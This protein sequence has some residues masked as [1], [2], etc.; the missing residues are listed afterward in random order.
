MMTIEKTL[1]LM[2]YFPFDIQRSHSNS[3]QN[4]PRPKAEPNTSSTNDAIPQKTKG[5]LSK[6][7]SQYKKPYIGTKRHGGGG[8]SHGT[9]R[10]PANMTLPSANIVTR[11]NY[12]AYSRSCVTRANDFKPRHYYRQKSRCCFIEQFDQKL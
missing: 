12:S 7:L 4:S 9:F 6:I 8:V 3:F 2:Y 1:L 10:V 11:G 5:C